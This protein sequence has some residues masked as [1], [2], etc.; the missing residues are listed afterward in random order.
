[1]EQRVEQVAAQVD[2]L[3]ELLEKIVHDRDGRSSHRASPAPSTAS[4]PTTQRRPGL[5]LVAPVQRADG[6]LQQLQKLAVPDEE[7]LSAA[8]ID[9][10]CPI[11]SAFRAMYPP[12]AVPAPV[13]LQA[14]KTINLYP[15]AQGIAA[16]EAKGQISPSPSDVARAVNEANRDK[17]VTRASVANLPVPSVTHIVAAMA[18][19][20]AMLLKCRV[21]YSKEYAQIVCHFLVNFSL[22]PPALVANLDVNCRMQ[23]ASGQL[24]YLDP[25]SHEFT[26]AFK[27]LVSD[28]FQQ[29]RLLE[30]LQGPPR[31]LPVAAPAPRQP[32]GAAPAANPAAKAPRR[33]DTGHCIKFNTGTC[34]FASCKYPHICSNPPCK[35]AGANHSFK[36]CAANPAR[37]Q[38]PGAGPAAQQA[39][40]AGS[41]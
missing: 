35:I 26:E 10:L 11:V 4:I 9:V 25:S 19:M 24:A 15:C 34:N 22:Y 33:P 20:Q 1:V 13:P 28:P 39:R 3:A 7:E 5:T 36:S 21:D 16:L 31:S 27:L 40:P 32:A 41:G 37:S 38:Q 12:F 30:R 8:G 29:M 18:M 14:G 6:L 17:V 23:A 2:K